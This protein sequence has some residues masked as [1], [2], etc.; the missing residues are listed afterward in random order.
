[1]GPL[2]L[3]Q[4]PTLEDKDRLMMAEALVKNPS[5]LKTYAKRNSSAAVAPSREEES[6][7]RSEKAHEPKAKE[8]A[9]PSGLEGKCTRKITLVIDR[10][11]RQVQATLDSPVLSFFW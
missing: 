4:N 7:P 9:V 2:E 1:L 5:L 3:Q 6:S 8:Q 11:N 10:K